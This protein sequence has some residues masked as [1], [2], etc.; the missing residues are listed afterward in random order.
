LDFLTTTDVGRTVGPDRVE[1]EAMS[2]ESEWELW[3]RKAKKRL[4]VVG[5]VGVRG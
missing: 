3:E 1:E 4:E 2:E 5:R